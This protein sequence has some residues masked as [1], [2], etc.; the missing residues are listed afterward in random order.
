M[1]GKEGVD[2]GEQIVVA[3]LV[4]PDDDIAIIV[5]LQIGDLEQL[6]DGIVAG[7]ETFG[8]P[9]GGEGVLFDLMALGGIKRHV[10]P[11]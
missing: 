4:G 2:A 1:V 3:S 6:G 11:P 9:C 5:G 10:R 8:L 7:G